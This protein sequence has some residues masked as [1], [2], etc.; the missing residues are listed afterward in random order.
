MDEAQVRTI[1]QHWILAYL[2]REVRKD[3][4]L[5]DRPDLCLVHAVLL[6]SSVVAAFVL[7]SQVP[8]DTRR[9]LLGSSTRSP[10]LPVSLPIP[11]PPRE[12]SCEDRGRELQERIGCVD[13]RQSAGLR[14]IAPTAPR[15]AEHGVGES[16]IVPARAEMDRRQI[17]HALDVVPRHRETDR[18]GFQTD[19]WQPFPERGLHPVSYTHL[20]LPTKSIV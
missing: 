11:L 17:T 18:R 19:P 10:N 7:S 8:G 2:A 9:T 5:N 12:R 13:V 16:V 14:Q 6:M 15:R 4:V 20:T 3:P 1:I